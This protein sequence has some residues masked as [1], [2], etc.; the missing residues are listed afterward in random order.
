MGGGGAAVEGG[1]FIL[2]SRWYPAP[3][4]DPCSRREK[5]AAGSPSL[6]CV[7]GWGKHIAG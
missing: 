6:R 1:M 7:C 2:S 3:R 4:D 5:G